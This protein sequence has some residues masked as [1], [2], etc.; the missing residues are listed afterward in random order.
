MLCRDL[1]LAFNWLFPF[2]DKYEKMEIIAGIDRC[3]IQP[4]LRDIDDNAW[5]YQVMNNWTTV[6]VG[7]LAI[8]GMSLRELHPQSGKLI[9]KAL[10]TMASYLTYYG[11]EGEF[12]EKEIG[13]ILLMQVMMMSFFLT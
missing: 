12:T 6:I 1:G 4:Y 8:C 2:L 10:K 13:S 9:E 7:G 11:P 3:G 5:W